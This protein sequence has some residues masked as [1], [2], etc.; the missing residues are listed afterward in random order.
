MVLGKTTLLKIIIG[1]LFSDNGRI[2][3][4]ENIRFGYFSQEH[5]ILNPNRTVLEEF[6]SIKK[7]IL[8][9]K[10]PRAILESFLFGGRNVFKKVSD[11]SFGERVRLIFAKLTNQENHFLI[12]DEP[13]NYLDI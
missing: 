3:I 5:E 4:G 12:L 8:L 9:S 10:N 7:S 11:L 6:L 13:T 2:K 1:E